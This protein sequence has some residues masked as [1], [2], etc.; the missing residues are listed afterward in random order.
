MAQF[1]R[2]F[3]YRPYIDVLNIMKRQ[4]LKNKSMQCGA[5]L[6]EALISILI[7]SIGLL[8]IAGIQLSAISYQKSSWSMHKVTEL[9][10][11]ISERIRSNPTGARNNNYIYT[12]DYATAKAATPTSN[13]CKSSS[14]FCSTAQIA[15]DDVTALI[16]QAQTLLP[17]GAARLEGDF[18]NGYVLTVMYFDKEFVNSTGVLQASTT[19]AASTSGIEWRNCCPA[20]ASTPDGVRCRR[21]NIIP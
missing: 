7:M 11:D 13:N 16:T 18:N 1:A 21:M 4:P 12:A 14:A 10:T 17:Q 20:G 3:E 2:T 8:G 5:T 6:I 15:S 19:C 9:S